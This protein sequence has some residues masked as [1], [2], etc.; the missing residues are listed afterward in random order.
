[1]G[2]ESLPYSSTVIHSRWMRG[3]LEHLAKLLPIGLL[4]G[5]VLF[6]VGLS[7][8]MVHVSP[9]LALLGLLAIPAGILLVTRPYLGL[10][11]IV[12]VIPLED[13]NELSGGVSLFKLLSAIVFG[14]TAV[15]FL[16]FRRKD[17]LAS[18]P[19]NWLIG[20]FL[21][22][23][24]LSNFTVIA[25]PVTLD[26]TLR[27]IYVLSLYLVAI[28]VIRTEKDLRYLVWAFLASGLIC[29]S[30]GFY[31]H[32]LGRAAAD[33]GARLTGTMDDPNEFAGA[34]VARLPLALCLLRVEK[35]WLKRLLL[36]VGAGM[37]ICGIIMT[38]S[39]G[40]LL[41]LV[42]ALALFVLRQKRKLAWLIIV[43]IIILAVLATMPSSLRARM[44]VMFSNE[45][46]ADTSLMRRMTYQIYGRK[47]FYQHPI[48]G[49]GF[50]RFSEA[51]ARSE[52]RFLQGP[53]KQVAHNTY[54]EIL[55]GT[56][57]M[58]FVPFMSLLVTALSTT[59][60]LARH[61]EKYPYRAHVSAGLFAG[62]G[63]YL[64]SSLFLSQQY[65]KTLW[66][67]IAMV[68][69]VR[70]LANSSDRQ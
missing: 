1:M 19:E 8:V 67:L 2:L 53:G 58:G 65:E 28:N 48:L 64:L 38:W 24:I 30:Y 27:L 5:G 41:A 16:V 45:Q 60:K 15:H 59:W 25:P 14:G 46:G 61:E 26:R 68:V 23:A 52:Y 51:Y 13:F 20:L 22:A 69:M 66:L 49:I 43:G 33:S 37:M 18:A 56:G 42:W 44:D 7:Y 11:L 9:A 47:L 36:L 39:R 10:L 3:S 29:V 17:R 32:F 6:S 62:L 34:V 40:G 54:L 57:L 4:L 21:L 35:H 12:L 63:G 70:R 55:V 31:G 50:S